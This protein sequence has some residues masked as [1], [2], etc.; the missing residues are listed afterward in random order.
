M[1]HGKGEDR[2]VLR[3]WK[4]V[5]RGRPARR[6]AAVLWTGVTACWLA[7]PAAAQA[8]KSETPGGNEGF[9]AHVLDLSQ[10][11]QKVTVPLHRSVTVETTVAVARAN[12]IAQQIAD[13]QVLSPTRMLI[14]G[15]SFGTTSVVLLGADEKQ[16]VF[17]VSVELD[18]EP[19]NRALREIDPLSSAKL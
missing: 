1:D 9:R 2:N 13:L 5:G 19:L 8:P 6:G 7:L 17:E 16:Y 12:V 3:R 18:L 10:R 11:Y 4:D 14:T 15:Q